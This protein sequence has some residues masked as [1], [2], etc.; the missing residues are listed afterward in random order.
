VTDAGERRSVVALLASVFT[1]SGAYL[2]VETALGKQV[3]DITGRE[4]DLGLLGLAEFAPAA[5]L[6]LVTG[7]V[8]DRFDRRKVTACGIAI[9]VVG[10]L[11]LAWYASGTRHSIGP[12]L[13]LAVVLGTGRAFVAPASRSLPADIVPPERL[14]WLIPRFSAT[15]QAAII[16]GPVFGG[17]LYAIRPWLPFVAVVLLLAVAA[18]S[19]LSI[20][21]PPRRQV[22]PVESPSLHTALE[23][24][25]FIRS[26][27]IIFGAIALDLFGVL[28]GGA[29]ALLP[30]IVE[31]R[32]GAGAVGLGWL[33]AAGGIGAAIVT[34]SLARRPLARHV[35]RRLLL[36]VA[37]FGA[38]T[39]FIAGLWWFLFPALRDVDEFP[40]EPTRAPAAG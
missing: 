13:A 9:E 14:T 39:L 1:T 31:E 11:G 3:Y 33:R 27:P 15:W 28:F 16:A 40:T 29:I 17:V 23:G 19:V 12:I 5:L 22:A 38:G 2:A 18:V 4:L 6:V 30:A 25:R 32:L 36:V 7:H 24:L 8:A 26:Q 34:L 35:G 37:I 10:V 20:S 21:L